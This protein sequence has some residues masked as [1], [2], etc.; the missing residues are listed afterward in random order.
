MSPVAGPSGLKGAAT[1]VE[2]KVYTFPIPILLL[3]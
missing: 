2:A 3:N 1:R